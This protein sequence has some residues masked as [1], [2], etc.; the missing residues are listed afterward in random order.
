MAR[1]HTHAVKGGKVTTTSK[2][3]PREV[4]GC[5]EWTEATVRTGPWKRIGNALADRIGRK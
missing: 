4:R 2:R 5:G 3:M 1:Q